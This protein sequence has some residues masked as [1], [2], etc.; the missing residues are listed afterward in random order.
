MLESLDDEV[1]DLLEYCKDENIEIVYEN[2]DDDY[3]NNND[4]D[5]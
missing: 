1:N 4:D 3:E 2:D 5:K